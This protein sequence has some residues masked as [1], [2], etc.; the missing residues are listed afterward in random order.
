MKFGVIV[1]PGSNCD[2]DVAY[3]TRDLLAQPTRMVWH[4]ETDISDL[5][6]V[7]IPGGFSYGDYLRC[8]AIARFS[9]VMKATVEHANKGKLVLGICNGFQVLT[10]AGLLPGALVR[11]RD[12]HFICDRVS[13]RVERTNLPWTQLYQTGQV[14][15]L[16]IAHGEGNYYADADTLAQLE[17]ND[18]V[19]FRYE[20]EN[21]N[22]S[23][24]NIAGICN[25]K[26]N[27]LGMM[28]HPERASDPM[29]GGT[30]GMKLFEGLLKVAVGALA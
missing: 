5:D 19:L 17:D 29:L 28:P 8:G 12:L 2:R 30:D 18:L 1:F 7:V 21:P 4:E 11:N 6:V 20:G 16:P 27:V 25:I 26:G 9:P 10:E 22:G 13:L 14:I 15:T 3:V 24:N 23:L